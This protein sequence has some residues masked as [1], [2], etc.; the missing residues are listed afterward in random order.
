M[1]TDTVFGG[2]RSKYARQARY[3]ARA[4]GRFSPAGRQGWGTD[5]VLW[6]YLSPGCAWRYCG[7]ATGSVSIFSGGLRWE[8]FAG[9]G[10]A[11]DIS[12]PGGEELS[13]GAQSRRLWGAGSFGSGCAGLRETCDFC[14]NFGSYDSARRDRSL[15]LQ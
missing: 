6:G 12:Q 15:I 10:V 9:D 11:A 2:R 14:E 3:L 4:V 1:G 8:V 7:V 13:E 5:T